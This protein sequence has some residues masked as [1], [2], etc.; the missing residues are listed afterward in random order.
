MSIIWNDIWCI[1]NEILDRV[2][3]PAPVGR[4]YQKCTNKVEWNVNAIS[5]TNPPLECPQ[6]QG[7]FRGMQLGCMLKFGLRKRAG[8]WWD[9]RLKNKCIANTRTT[10]AV[11]VWKCLDVLVR[12][13][14]AVQLLYVCP[15][16]RREKNSNRYIEGLCVWAG[17]DGG[18]HVMVVQECVGMFSVYKL[19]AYIHIRIYTASDCRHSSL[20]RPTMQNWERRRH[21]FYYY[22][23]VCK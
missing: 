22:L 11:F 4:E 1:R 6:S 12:A 5:V 16:F 14:A 10:N 17:V 9:W 13:G 20:V 18:L 23:S 8:S 2:Q 19:Y 3:S 7:I 15:A 21:S